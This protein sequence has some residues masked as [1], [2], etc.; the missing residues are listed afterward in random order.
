[1]STDMHLSPFLKIFSL[2]EK[3][4]ARLL[5]STKTCALTLLHA[6]TLA[7]V[8]AGKAARETMDTLVRLGMVVIDP[9]KEQREMRGYLNE[10]NRLNP[11]LR[12]SVILG[13]ACNF[14][15]V[16][17]YEGSMKVAA[18]MDDATAEQLSTYLLAR[19]TP[20]KKR[21]ILDFYGGE[22]LLYVSRIKS[23]ATRLKPLIEARGGTFEFTLV[24]NGS[25]L[26]AEMAKELVALGLVSAKITVDGPEEN[27]NR[28]RPGKD[29]QGSWST[30]LANLKACCGIFPI[31]LSGNYTCDNFHRFPELLDSLGGMGFGPEAFAS[32]QFYPVMQVN[33]QFANPEFSGGC[34]SMNEPWLVEAS[35]FLR[36]EIMRRGYPFP[37]LQPAPCMVDLDD[38]FTVNH[39]GAIYKCVTLI[40]HQGYEAGDIWHGMGN[41][42]GE[43]HC[44][45]HWQKEAHCQK[46]EYLPLCFGG[47]RY[48]AFQREG[49]MAGVDC[50]KEFL[51]ATLEKMLRQDLKYRYGA[52][53]LPTPDPAA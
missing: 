50:Q 8:Q 15:C 37:K 38:A 34:C 52:E 42:W 3:K 19:F 24:T 12:V 44:L 29:G 26:T 11:N 53:T 33:D 21:L 48:M 22:P 20:E 30:I 9:A 45:G 23:L 47:C 43:K 46:C 1:M 10:V 32:V 31:F 49:D 39:D 28:F 51:D 27:H 41:D 4:E 14:A 25:L 17:C 40:G 16:Y 13:L 36:E 35:L 18:A 2:P 6:E 5:F 7:A